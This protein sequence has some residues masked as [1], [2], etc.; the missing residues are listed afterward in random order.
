MFTCVPMVSHK[1]EKKGELADVLDALEEQNAAA[2][3]QTILLA[4]CRQNQCSRHDLI[5]FGKEM[6]QKNKFELFF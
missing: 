5:M 2:L 1:L 6:H 3:C 4:V